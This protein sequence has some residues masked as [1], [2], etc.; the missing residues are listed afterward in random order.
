MLKRP[1]N[2]IKN[3]DRIEITI[4]ITPFYKYSIEKEKIIKKI[5][6]GLYIK[7]QKV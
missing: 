3:I 5:K 2:K 6:K 7:I 1:V 4:E